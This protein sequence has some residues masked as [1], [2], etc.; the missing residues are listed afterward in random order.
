M[1]AADTFACEE[2]GA[3]KRVPLGSEM[4]MLEDV[5]CY[6]GLMLSSRTVVESCDGYRGAE[7]IRCR[8]KECAESC[9]SVSN[10]RGSSLC[11][12]SKGEEMLKVCVE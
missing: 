10:A 5:G 1:T 12:G 4:D 7:I 6:S 11:K 9:W 2:D 8:T 3:A